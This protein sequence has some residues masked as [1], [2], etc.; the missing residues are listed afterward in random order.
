MKSP[1]FVCL[2]CSSAVVVEQVHIFIS[3]HVAIEL[4]L[5]DTDHKIH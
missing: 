1:P 4:A 2:K 3:Y 5:I